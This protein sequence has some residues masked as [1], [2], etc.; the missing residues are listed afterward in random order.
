MTEPV[1]E[2]CNLS[3]QFG[4][5][6]ATD[7]ISLSIAANEIHAIIGPNGAGKTTLV[8]QL[9][10]SLQ[11]DGGKIRFRGQDITSL[12]TYKRSALG[13]ARSF[14]ITSLIM[15]M[16]VL[17]NIALGVQAHQGHS[18]KF[19]KPARSIESLRHKASE[20]L[21]QIE[22]IE[23]ADSKVSALSHGERRQVEIAVAL[24][25]D[26]V[27]LLLD[28]PTAGMGASESAQMVEILKRMKGEKTIVLVE[29]DM[30]AVFALADKISVLVYGQIIA[31][32]TPDEIRQNEDVRHAYLGEA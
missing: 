10:G 28:E 16:T 15:S 7:N 3:K 23:R 19:W 12:A 9:S 24:A 8:S 5:V 25:T 26:P 30:D 29:H 31:T 27:L 2:I 21:E 18:F 1:L 11:P 14:Q 17:D 4:G 22:L 20:I 6:K 13:L 32:G